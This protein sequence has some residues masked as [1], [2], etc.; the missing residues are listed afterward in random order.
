MKTRPD[1]IRKNKPLEDR[2]RPDRIKLNKTTKDYTRPDKTRH[3]P[4]LACQVTGAK[5]D[6]NRPD[7]TKT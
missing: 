7:Q 5:Q 6:R 3:T 1:H 4:V 2:T